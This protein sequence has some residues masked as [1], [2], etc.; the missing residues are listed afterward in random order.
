MPSLSGLCEKLKVSVCLLLHWRYHTKSDVPSFC[1]TQSCFTQEVS[2][3]FTAV[4]S[5]TTNTLEIWRTTP[6]DQPGW[7]PLSDTHTAVTIPL[8]IASF[9]FSWNFRQ[10]QDIF[11]AQFLLLCFWSAPS[12]IHGSRLPEPSLSAWGSVAYWDAFGT[13]SPCLGCYWLKS[14]CFWMTV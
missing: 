3:N 4:S 6:G 8:I 11:S 2:F 1:G 14:S 5:S 7:F 10:D 12:A 9:L 13:Q